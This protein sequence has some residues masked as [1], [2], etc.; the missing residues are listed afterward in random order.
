VV[1]THIT[2][3]RWGEVPK[4]TI[5][6]KITTFLVLLR[7]LLEILRRVLIV[8]SE[9]EVVAVVYGIGFVV[10]VVVQVIMDEICHHPTLAT[11]IIVIEVAMVSFVGVTS[12]KKIVQ[13]G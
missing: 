5:T 7:I 11:Q 3:P 12:T 2:L 1:V 9:E 4:H 6:H 10:A 8:A 13:N